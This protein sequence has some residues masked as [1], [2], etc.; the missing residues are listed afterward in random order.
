MSPFSPDGDL[1]GTPVVFSPSVRR[2]RGS[3]VVRD[4]RRQKATVLRY[5]PRL[6]R[7]K[8]AQQSAPFSGR[9]LDVL[10]SLQLQV[11]VVCRFQ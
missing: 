3:Q 6:I 2:R 8:R 10:A 5:A 1:A 7:T 9:V 11:G 4:V